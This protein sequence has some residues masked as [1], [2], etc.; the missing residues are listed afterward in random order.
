MGKR[1]TSARAKEIVSTVAQIVEATADGNARLIRK[2]VVIQ[3]SSN[4]GENTSPYITRRSGRCT[5]NCGSFPLFCRQL[6]GRPQC[7]NLAGRQIDT[8]ERTL[9]ADTGVVIEN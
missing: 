7:F 5:G 2:I 6:G 8:I 3:K 1:T 4:R 9:R